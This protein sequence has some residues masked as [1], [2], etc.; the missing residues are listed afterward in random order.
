MPGPGFMNFGTKRRRK[1]RAY[2]R[3]RGGQIG[4]NVGSMAYSAYKTGQWLKSVINPELKFLDTSYAASMA[5]AGT[6]QA[7]NLMGQGDTVSTRDGNSIKLQS[8]TAR[9]TFNI[10]AAGSSQTVR[11]LFFYDT[12][13]QG[14]APAV[15]DVLVAADPD[16]LM[17]LTSYPGRFKII[18]DYYKS[19]NPAG[20]ASLNFRFYRKLPI[21]L[22]YTDLLS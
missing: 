2:W 17:N 15:T 21:H 12:Q 10:A 9:L 20:Q 16:S 6:V 18:R 13:N 19:V 5:T 8:I 14:A 4:R 11:C 3:K 7:L 22:K 1:G